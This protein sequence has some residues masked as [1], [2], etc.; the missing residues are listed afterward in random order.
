MSNKTIISAFSF[1]RLCK[2]ALNAICQTLTFLLDISLKHCLFFT[3]NLW[4]FEFK[5]SEKLSEGCSPNF[6]GLSTKA[7]LPAFPWENEQHIL[8]SH[9]FS[10]E[11]KQKSGKQ[12]SYDTSLDSL[13]FFTSGVAEGCDLLSS[14]SLAVSI[15][16][17][18]SKLVH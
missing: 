7:L 4:R 12:I 10:T 3:G 17:E 11:E 5:W 15:L 1:T 16:L 8:K 2:D 18:I 6:P 13:L 9:P 14:N